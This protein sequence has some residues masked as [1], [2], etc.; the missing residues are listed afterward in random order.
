MRSQSNV[1]YAFFGAVVGTVLALSVHLWSSWATRSRAV[2][3]EGEAAI[4]YALTQLLGF[5]TNFLWS[6][7]V[8]VPVRSEYYVLLL[9]IVVNWAM[10]ALGI[11]FA[12]QRRT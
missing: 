8:D 11:G 3:P 2:T 6:L 9:G 4:T 10:L 7:L 12:K 1:R 5:P